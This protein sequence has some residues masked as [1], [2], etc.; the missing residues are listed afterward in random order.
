MGEL[1]ESIELV[2]IDG[3]DRRCIL[4]R[5][6]SCPRSLILFRLMVSPKSFQTCDKQSI[7]DWSFYWVWATTNASSANSMSRARTLRTFVL[8]RS[9]ARFNSLPSDQVRK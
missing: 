8:A 7:N 9:R 3:N 2:V 5:S 4:Y 6:V 1:T